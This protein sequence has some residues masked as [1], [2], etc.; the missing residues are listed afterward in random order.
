M[1]TKVFTSNTTWRK[2]TIDLYYN[3]VQKVVLAI[4]NKLSEEI[5]LQTMAEIAN[6]SPYHFNVSVHSPPLLYR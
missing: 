6:L 2:D 1:L 4:H 3:A 5:N